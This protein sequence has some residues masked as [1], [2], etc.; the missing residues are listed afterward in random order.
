MDVAGNQAAHDDHDLKGII[1]V[2]FLQHLRVIQ[3]NGQTKV[4]DATV[5]GE[6]VI[7]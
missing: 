4:V 3:C 7:I 6:T 1:R 2:F 5:I